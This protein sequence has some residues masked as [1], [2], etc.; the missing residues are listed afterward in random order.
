MVGMFITWV[1][2]SRTWVCT[3]ENIKKTTEQG[4]KETLSPRGI[5]FCRDSSLKLMVFKSI[6][7]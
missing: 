4:L 7:K 6:Q 5:H 1:G 3:Q 2:G